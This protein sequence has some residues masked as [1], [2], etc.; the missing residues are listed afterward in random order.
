MSEGQLEV[1]MSSQAQLLTA[2]DAELAAAKKEVPRCLL[3]S[4][5]FIGIEQYFFLSI[6]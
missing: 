2:K 3:L 4:V 5:D 6:K 1:E